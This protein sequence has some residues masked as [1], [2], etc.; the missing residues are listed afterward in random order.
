MIFYGSAL[1]SWLKL[2]HLML[3]LYEETCQ[4]G[5]AFQDQAIFHIYHGAWLC[6][7]LC[8]ASENAHC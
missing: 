1:L 6:I 3:Q 8:T 5:D 2:H 7:Q 4:P